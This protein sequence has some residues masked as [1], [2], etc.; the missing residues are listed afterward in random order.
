VV[1][2]EQGGVGLGLNKSQSEE[3]RDEP[4][5]PCLRRLLQPIE[6]LVEAVDLV[7][8]RGINKPHRLAIVDCIWESTMYEHILHI[9]LVDGSGA[10]DGQGKYC[11]DGGRLDNQA[12]CLIVVDARP[13]GEAAKNPTSLVLF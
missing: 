6:R 8:L 12:E 3:V 1:E 9:K 13:L 10:W 4:T 11:A 2:D 7:R 5:V